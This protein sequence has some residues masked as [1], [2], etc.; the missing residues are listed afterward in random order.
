MADQNDLIQNQRISNRIVNLY[1]QYI[2]AGGSARISMWQ[3]RED[4]SRIIPYEDPW[5]HAHFSVLARDAIENDRANGRPVYNIGGDPP[6][7]HIHIRDT[8]P[9]I[10]PPPQEEQQQPQIPLQFNQFNHFERFEGQ[11]QLDHRQ[12]EGFLQQQQ[13]YPPQQIQFPPH[14]DMF[15]RFD[16]NPDIEFRERQAGPEIRRENQ[17]RGIRRRK[18][19]S[20]RDGERGREEDEEWGTDAGYSESE[21]DEKPPLPFEKRKQRNTT[22]ISKDRQTINQAIDAYRE[23]GISYSARA[24][25]RLADKPIHFPNSLIKDLLQFKF[26]DMEKMLQEISADDTD[27]NKILEF[28]PNSKKLE[29]KA[30]QIKRRFK[31]VGEWRKVTEA[32]NTALQMAFPGAEE[33]FEKYFEHLKQSEYTYETWGDWT[34]VVWYDKALRTEFHNRAYLSYA[35]FDHPELA[36][37]KNQNP[38]QQN[39]QR[40]GPSQYRNNHQITH[41][42]NQ[43]PRTYSSH[44]FPRS[45]WSGQIKSQPASIKD[46]ICGNWNLNR[47]PLANCPRIHNRCDFIGCPGTH[48][49]IDN[50]TPGGGSKKEV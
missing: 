26:I 12:Q 47:C 45:P 30:K 40:A 21:T 15:E 18:K 17:E 48:R 23:A 50:H 49:R 1:N 32:Y 4:F 22:P 9:W 37:I 7:A 8:L 35:D 39:Q 24:F 19:R 5:F 20:R 27:R 46:Q 2:E 33:S 3:L 44:G 43:N 10:V 41:Q 11:Q 13:Q 14:Q 6:P 25:E 34:R 42:Q 29:S 36:A 31:S 28:D 38:N 16:Q